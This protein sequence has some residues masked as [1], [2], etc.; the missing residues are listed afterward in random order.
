[1]AR[2]SVG[3]NDAAVLAAVRCTADGLGRSTA[4]DLDLRD[5]TGLTISE[6][7]RG[8]IVLTALGY[9]RQERCVLESGAVHITYHISRQEQ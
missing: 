8:R 6:V 5:L 9:L 2:R 7:R 1:M 4:S 3:P